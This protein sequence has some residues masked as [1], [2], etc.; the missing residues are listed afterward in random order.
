MNRRLG[1]AVPHG[2]VDGG[3]HDSERGSVVSFHFELRLGRRQR[4]RRE[5]RRHGWEKRRSARSFPAE[6]DPRHRRHPRD[7]LFFPDRTNIDVYPDA[8]FDAGDA[9]AQARGE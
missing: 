7:P 9:E 4:P 1:D 6:N 3:S 2:G 5:L 8:N